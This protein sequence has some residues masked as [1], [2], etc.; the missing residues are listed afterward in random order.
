VL[1]LLMYTSMVYG[2]YLIQATLKQTEQ[3]LRLVQV[4]LLVL[5]LNS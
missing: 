5:L 2:R 4:F 1:I 3:L